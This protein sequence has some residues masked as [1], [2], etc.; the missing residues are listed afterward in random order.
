MPKL[1]SKNE[2]N[3]RQLKPLL[4]TNIIYQIEQSKK[5]EEPSPCIL[6]GPPGI[7]KSVYLEQICENF[8]YGL[9]TLYLSNTLLHQLTGLPRVHVGT[10]NKKDDKFV[11]WS[12]PDIFDLRNMKVR[13]KDDSGEP[14]KIEEIA[15]KEIPVILFLDD[16]HLCARRRVA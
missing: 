9:V 12:W 5:G 14:M 8:N 16:I 4:I 3:L 7:G 11:P 10:E 2:L 15:K 6:W 1:S 13:P